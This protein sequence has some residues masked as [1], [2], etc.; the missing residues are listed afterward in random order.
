MSKKV[1]ILIA[2]RGTEEPEFTKPKAALEEAG[3][4]VTVVGLSA[5]EAETVNNDLD[6]ASR[7]AVDKVIGDVAE[8][9]YDAVVVPG[10]TVGADKLRAS[11]EAVGFVR[12]FLDAGKPVAAICHAPWVLVETG[13][14]SGRT[15][16]SYP[17][18]QTDI[19]NAGATWVDKEVVRDAGLITSRNPDD[20]PAFCKAL[21]AELRGGE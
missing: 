15:L 1:A 7:I 14:L 3:M 12:A 9:D 19:R 8:P 6:P 13:Q 4:E 18:V 11:E 10:G 20:L 16:T 21:I 17:T 5:D 2:P